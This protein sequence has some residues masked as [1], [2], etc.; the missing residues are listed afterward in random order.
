[1]RYRIRPPIKP[2]NSLCERESFS[3]H[4]RDYP[5]KKSRR[6][7]ILDGGLSVNG[8]CDFCAMA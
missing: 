7:C 4:Q 1:M 6:N 2:I 3:Q 8:D 5:I